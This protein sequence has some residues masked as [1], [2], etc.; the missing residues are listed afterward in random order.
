MML[1]ADTHIS[2]RTVDFLRT[3]G[4]DVVRVSEILSPQTSDDSGR[5][6]R[7]STPVAHHVSERL[8]INERPL[9][10]RTAATRRRQ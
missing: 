9:P 7:A 6:A 3:L 1:L 10:A 5:S 8:I 2:P 4:H